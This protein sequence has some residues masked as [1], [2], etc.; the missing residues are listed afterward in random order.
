MKQII[1][2]L[3][4]EKYYEILTR[5]YLNTANLLDPIPIQAYFCDVVNVARIL[6]K[7]GSNNVRKMLG[8]GEKKFHQQG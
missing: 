6:H 3:K 4:F 8:M 2:K 5:Q 7:R 1:E